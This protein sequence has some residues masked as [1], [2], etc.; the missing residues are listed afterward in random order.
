MI[1]LSVITVDWYLGM[2]ENISASCDWLWQRSKSWTSFISGRSRR[3]LK[4][5]CS[6]TLA[7]RNCVALV[8]LS[9]LS[10]PTLRTMDLWAQKMRHVYSPH[11]HGIIKFQY[12][13]NTCKKREYWSWKH[14][15]GLT[16]PGK[17]FVYNKSFQW[18]L[19]VGLVLAA[20]LNMTHLSRIISFGF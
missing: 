9:R 11:Y 18:K 13:P 2:K 16:I 1:N 7:R 12:S 19:H 4:N 20:F 10:A 15:A 3:A 8:L 5:R 14:C 6:G 17:Y